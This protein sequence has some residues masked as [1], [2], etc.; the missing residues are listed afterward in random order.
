MCYGNLVSPRKLIEGEDEGLGAHRLGTDRS[1]SDK[2][3]SEFLLRACHDLRASVRAIGV[4]AERLRKDSQA[5]Q[6]VSDFEQRLKFILDGAR[7]IESL[8]D[9]LSA[10][11][12][13]LQIEEAS[14]QSTSMGLMLRTAMARLDTELRAH[15]AEVTCGELP[16]VS[17]NP[18]RLMQIFETLLSNALR[19]RG[20]RPPRIHITAEKR[21]EEWL[22][23]VRDNGPGIDTAYLER[24]F[25]PFE[26]LRSTER[27]ATGLGLAICRAIVKR[28][29]GKLWADS[30]P[31]TGSVFLF[32]LP[33]IG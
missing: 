16:R 26:R 19:H 5:P 3:L 28:H 12:V 15:E 27:D 20:E 9:G 17:G 21:E 14:F 30:T 18:D 31:G 29:G 13:A 11:S 25:R 6:P 33:A 1:T 7:K 32:T 2:D 4:H 8:T 10:Y 24:I 23:A 22:F